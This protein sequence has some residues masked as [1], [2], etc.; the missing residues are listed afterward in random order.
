VMLLALVATTMVGVTSALRANT[1]RQRQILGAAE[2][3]N[4]LMV[5]RADDEELMPSPNLPVAYGDEMYRWQITIRP[6]GV[7]ISEAGREAAAETT[8]TISFAQ[9]LEAVEVTVWL[10]EE[11]GG[12]I[13]P[14]PGIPRATLARIVDPLAFDNFDRDQRALESPDGLRRITQTM[15]ELTTGTGAT[16]AVTIGGDQ[17]AG[18]G[19]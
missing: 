7:R 17:Q 10:S 4:R 5:I 9:R 3:A 16:E 8:E 19:G 1:E 14:L 12:S 18:G 6:V 2:M 11:S 15:L 13:E